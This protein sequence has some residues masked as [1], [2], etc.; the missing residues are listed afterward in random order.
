MS[1]M[2]DIDF[3][4][5]A[6]RESN[7]NLSRET[8]DFH[9]RPDISFIMMTDSNCN[10]AASVMFV[11]NPASNFRSATA[12]PVGE[13]AHTASTVVSSLALAL[14]TF[15]PSPPGLARASRMPVPPLPAWPDI[16]LSSQTKVPPSTVDFGNGWAIRTRLRKPGELAHGA[17]PISP[18][19]HEA[20]APRNIETS[21][22]PD[23]RAHY[24]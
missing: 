19:R 13:C 6:Q 18:A 21:E 24:L 15:A 2:D 23:L 9:K 1:T 14:R 12:N 8:R 11:K 3:T 20:A 5:I 4:S 7:L 10:H 22:W 16:A 17:R